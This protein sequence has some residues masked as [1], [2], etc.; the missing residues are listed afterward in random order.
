MSSGPTLTGQTCIEATKKQYLN[1]SFSR[2]DWCSYKG[3]CRIDQMLAD[4]NFACLL[5][6]YRTPL[7]VPKFL[8]E[9][10]NERHKH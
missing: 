10:H 6:K 4:H 7:D 5:C 8:E 2:E 1:V 9:K 3:H